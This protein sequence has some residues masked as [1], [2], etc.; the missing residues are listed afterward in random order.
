MMNVCGMLVIRFG[1]YLVER[2]TVQSHSLMQDSVLP[3]E[4][5]FIG[6][7]EASRG[8]ERWRRSH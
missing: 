2:T 1:E 4:D 5:E 3:C 8:A 7:D 6:Y